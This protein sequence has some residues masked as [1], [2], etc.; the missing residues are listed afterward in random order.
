MRGDSL[1][2]LGI[3][4]AGVLALLVSGCQML[5]DSGMDGVADNRMN[6]GKRELTY[7]LTDSGLEMA[8]AGREY[9]LEQVES[10]SGSQYVAGDGSETEFWNKGER[11]LVT[12]EG[13]EL[14]ECAY[15]S[16]PTLSGPVWMVT[17]IDGEPVMTNYRASMH[18]RPEGRVGGRASCNHFNASWE[19]LGDQLVIERS[20]VTKMACPSAVM[21]QERRFLNALA[22]VSG[23]RVTGERVLMLLGTDGATLIQAEPRSRTSTS[24]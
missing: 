12:L 8:I 7:S 5:P 3:L 22:R 23:F 24:R 13:V 15:A 6:C 18:F 17:A 2:R 20:S 9:E 14:P 4:G 19:R 16:G 21:D 1:T 10:A 11:A